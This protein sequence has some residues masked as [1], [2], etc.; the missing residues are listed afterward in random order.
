MP[1][2]PMPPMPMPPMPMPPM[3]MP[4]CIPPPPNPPPPPCPPPPPPPPPWAKADELDAIAITSPR[5][6]V[7]KAT[8]ALPRLSRENIDVL[9]VC[10]RVLCWFPRRRPSQGPGRAS[11]RP[12]MLSPDI[13][14][15]KV[16]AE[17]G[18]GSPS[19]LIE[20]VGELQSVW[21]HVCREPVPSMPHTSV[22]GKSLRDS[23]ARSLG[24]YPEL[25]W[26]LRSDLEQTHSAVKNLP[27]DGGSFAFS[28]RRR[29]FST[30]ESSRNPRSV[31]GF[32]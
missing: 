21:P 31:F 2:M 16:Y 13:L 30:A 4:P 25:R 29:E 26:S 11:R 6:R 32:K 9:L 15:Y 22:W 10:L 1:P 19:F 20:I 18:P 5:P 8:L 7:I 28:Q 3:P 23:P 14:S 17:I 12:D 27:S 24:S